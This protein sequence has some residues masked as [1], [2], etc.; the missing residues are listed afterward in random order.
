MLQALAGIA[1]GMAG[2]AKWTA[3][4]V[5]GGIWRGVGGV[6]AAQMAK[7]VQRNDPWT[8]QDL[9]QRNTDAILR[10]VSKVSDYNDSFTHSISVKVRGGPAADLRRVYYLALAAAFGRYSRAVSY[11]IG[12]YTEVSAHTDVSN[13]EVTVTIGYSVGMWSQLFRG[14]DRL[15]TTSNVGQQRIRTEFDVI[16]EGPDQVTIGSGWPTVL[17]GLLG[18]KR[19]PA[20]SGAAIKGGGVVSVPVADY[21][22]PP[23]A[24]WTPPAFGGLFGGTARLR[25]NVGANVKWVLTQPEVIRAIKVPIAPLKPYVWS[26]DEFDTDVLRELPYFNP[27]L[28]DRR[29][30]LRD[31]TR[32]D[33]P[34]FTQV[35]TTSDAEMPVLPDD[36][37]LI[38]T[39]ETGNPLVQPPRP[40][41]DG[42]ARGSLVDM[43]KAALATPGYLPPLP[44]MTANYLATSGFHVYPPGILADAAARN[45]NRFRPSV[46]PLIAGRE[47]GLVNEAPASTPKVPLLRDPS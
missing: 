38:T 19:Y 29:V 46:P 41:V 25:F 31:H 6:G 7:A 33:Q 34:T 3:R 35:R 23:N 40:P 36:G 13:K 17:T 39:G 24:V 27:T 44:P 28:K 14:A 1:R 18:S 22:T 32:A 20:G 37:R 15:V 10:M 12:T 11:T 30:Y 4:K 9:R 2:A 16:Y 8:I 47:G 42:L 21:E 45:Q 26:I 5:G 43:V